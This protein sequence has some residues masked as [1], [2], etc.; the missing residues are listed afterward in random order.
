MI[1]L[2]RQQA[3]TEVVDLIRGQVGGLAQVHQVGR[4]TPCAPLVTL[5]QPEFDTFWTSTARTE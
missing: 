2:K 5:N 3:L 1:G 4:A